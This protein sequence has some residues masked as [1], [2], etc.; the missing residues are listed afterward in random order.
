MKHLE[1]VLNS[2]FMCNFLDCVR[3][4]IEEALMSMVD[5]VDWLGLGLVRNRVMLFYS[6]C[7][8]LCILPVYFGAPP[9]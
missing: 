4:C 1:Q 2:L 6:F 7:L 5:F 3:H 8:A 9:L